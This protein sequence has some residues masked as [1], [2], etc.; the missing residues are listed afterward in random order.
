MDERIKS[1][2]DALAANLEGLAEDEKREALDYYEEYFSDALEEGADPGELLSRLDPPEKIAAAIRAE[3][4]IRLVNADPGLKNYSRLVKSAHAGITGPLSVFLLSLVIFTTYSIAIILFLCTVVSAAAA[5]IILPASISEAF[6]IPARYI[7]EIAGTIGMGIFAS[8]VCL[9]ISYGFYVLCR[10][11]IR[12]SAG[13]VY[14]MVKKGSKPGSNTV[15]AHKDVSGVTGPKRV[16]RSL[17]AGLIITAAGL[18][19]SLA[20][21]LPVKLFMIFNSMKPADITVIQREFGMDGVSEISIET[22]HSNIRL[23]EG[24]SGNISLEYEKS[25]W[26]D[27]DIKSD[28][29]RVVFTERSNGRLPLFSLVS[30]HENRAELIISLPSGWE[31]GSVRLESRGGTINIESGSFPVQAKTYTGTI[32]LTVPA[33]GDLQEIPPAIRA[34]SSKGAIFLQDKTTGAKRPYGTEYELQ[35][36]GGVTIRLES[37]RGNIVLD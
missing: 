23:T 13:M 2:L 35:S 36:P 27:F 22:A 1:F 30:L 12:V 9:L 34:K 29:G 21:G 19:V 15:E 11:L 18:A 16:N 26:L 32:H 6:K 28:G 31:P 10:P 5:C 14:K 33:D 4:S 24:G 17:R 25:N 37:E 20:S 7:G 3:T 8:G